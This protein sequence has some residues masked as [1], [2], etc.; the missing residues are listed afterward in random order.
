MSTAFPFPFDPSDFRFFLP[1][2]SPFCLA[3]VATL[4]LGVFKYPSI[5]SSNMPTT[6]LVPPDGDAPNA[7][8][9]I[10]NPAR[11]ISCVAFGG[12]PL[13]FEKISGM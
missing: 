7:Y 6:P 3:L 9:P 5:P 12:L 1:D 10:P 8:N 13:R 2:F 11:R 4:L